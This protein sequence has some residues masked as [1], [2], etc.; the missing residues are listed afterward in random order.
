[1]FS[2]AKSFNQDL[3][4]WTVPLLSS[5]PFYFDGLATSWLPADQKRPCWGCLPSLQLGPAWERA[6]AASAWPDARYR[7]FVA[8]SRDRSE[9]IPGPNATQYFTVTG[10]KKVDLSALPIQYSL[11]FAPRTPAQYFVYSDTGAMFYSPSEADLDNNGTGISLI[12]PLCVK[13]A[14]RDHETR[15]PRV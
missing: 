10:N 3:S 11:K 13:L 7:R 15:T 6:L 1:M 5:E 12:E 2:E 14:A 9:R 8:G 4:G